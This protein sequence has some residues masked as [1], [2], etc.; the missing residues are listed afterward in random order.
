V[1]IRRFIFSEL[2]RFIRDISTVSDDLRNSS[3]L[4]RVCLN[5][6]IME[7]LLIHLY[8]RTVHRTFNIS[9]HNV[10][11]AYPQ[12]LAYFN[13]DCPNKVIMCL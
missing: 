12:H 10:E 9:D 3:F 6:E 5:T 4:H 8:P 1:L 2:K 13:D 7:Y 11:S